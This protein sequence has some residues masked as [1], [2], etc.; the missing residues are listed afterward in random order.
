MTFP[1]LITH[2]LTYGAILTVLLSVTFLSLFFVSPASW[3]GDYPPDIKAR[4]GPMDARARKWK[5]IFA[6]PTFAIMVGVT[7]WSILRLG[8]IA[9]PALTFW[10]VA[11]SVFIIW[12]V[13]NVV[14]L[15]ILDWLVFVTLQPKGIVLPGTEGMAGYKDYGFHL[16]GSL[17]GQVGIA[18]VSLIFAALAMLSI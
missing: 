10:H 15:L 9:G 17:K 7:G 6:I 18:I 8:E 3:V 11:L 5:G 13:F 14:D 12:T 4:F 16:R 1:T 2:S